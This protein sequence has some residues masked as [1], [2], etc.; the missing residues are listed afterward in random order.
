MKRYEH[1]VNDS[2]IMQTRRERCF[3]KSQC[4]SEEKQSEKRSKV[5]DEYRF[6]HFEIRHIKREE[7]RQTCYHDQIIQ[8]NQS[9]DKSN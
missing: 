9:V 1:S 3:D 8:R 4:F 2:V 7:T 6:N 5:V